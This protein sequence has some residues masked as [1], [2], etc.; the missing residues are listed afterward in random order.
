MTPSEELAAQLLEQLRGLAEPERARGEKA[1][2]KSD[3]EFL[4]VPV[5]A[6]RRILRAFLSTHGIEDHDDVVALAR[7]LWSG[8]IHEQRR[9]AVEVLSARTAVLGDADLPLIADMVRDGETW[10]LVDGL[11][12]E[13]AATIV[14]RGVTPRAGE[15]LDRCAADPDSFWVR[16]LA[17]LALLRS[18][19]FDSTE[20]ERFS[21]Y[22]DGMLAER[23]FFIRKAIGWVLRE[24]SKRDPDLVRGWVAAREGMLSGVTR[25]EA[26]KYL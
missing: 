19:K 1:Y 22:A 26:V 25:R 24:V 17:L 23:E 18:L 21:R 6:G 2:L 15:W 12:G 16:R 5:P 8:P 10:A 7:A 20:W 14:A 9:A 3:R 4:G 11:A 13:V